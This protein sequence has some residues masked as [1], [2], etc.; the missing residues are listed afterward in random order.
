MKRLALIFFLVINTLAFS[1]D[2][3]TDIN[4]ATSDMYKDFTSLSSKV[5]TFRDFKSKYFKTT[6]EYA[7]YLKRFS[8]IYYFVDELDKYNF[9]NNTN[10]T[11]WVPFYFAPAGGFDIMNGSDTAHNS[12]GVNIA[13]NYRLYNLFNNKITFYAVNSSTQNGNFNNLTGLDINN[14]DKEGRIRLFE[15]IN[16]FT[17]GL[18]YNIFNSFNSNQAISK[19]VFIVIPKAF[20]RFNLD[21]TPYNETGFDAITGIDYRIPKIEVNSI[22]T[23]KLNYSYTDSILKKVDAV[24]FPFE[25]ET[26]Y[27]HRLTLHL[28]EKAVWNKQKPGNTYFTGNYLSATADFGIPLYDTFNSGKFTF[29]GQIE[30][31]YTKNLFNKDFFLRGRGLIGI[32]YNISDNLSGDGFIRGLSKHDFTGFIYFVGNLELSLPAVYVNLSAAAD[33]PFKKKANF[34]LFLTLFSD[35]GVA[36]ENY[37]YQINGSYTRYTED[38][39]KDY[40]LKLFG[41]NIY[42]NYAW[43]AGGGLRIYPYFMHFIIRFDVGVNVLESI[44]TKKSPSIEFVLAFNDMF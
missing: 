6:P 37:G 27:R 39:L 25:A 9:R 16:V 23:I 34:L 36:V 1:Q 38:Y 13:F 31:K 15:S 10:V 35:F 30:D 28:I 29:R 26:L 17:T 7:L 12:N 32:N 43:T 11:L 44:L 41:D 2:M 8:H 20:K 5:D 4:D 3:T 19:N 40:R 33:V 14:V 24:T 18:N 22:S 42:L 21:L